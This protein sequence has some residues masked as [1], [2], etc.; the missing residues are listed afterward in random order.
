M[1]MATMTTGRFPKHKAKGIQ[2][3]LAKPIDRTE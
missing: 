3:K 1:A 2:N